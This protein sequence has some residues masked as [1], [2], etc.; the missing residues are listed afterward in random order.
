M[1]DP[2]T[3]DA[4]PDRLRLGLLGKAR[5]VTGEHAPGSP[6][7]SPAIRDLV[8]QSDLVVVDVTTP[9]REIFVEWGWGIGAK[10]QVLLGVY[11]SG[12]RE[13]HPAWVQERQ[14]R[15]FGSKSEFDEFLGQVLRILDSFPD[16]VSSWVDDPCNEPLDYKPAPQNVVLLGGLEQW[17]ALRARVAETAKENKFSLEVLDVQTRQNE[18][19]ILFDTIRAARKAATLVLTFDGSDCDLLACV[20]GGVFSM[21]DAY[22]IGSRKHQRK[23]VLLKRDGAPLPGLLATKPGVCTLSHIGESVDFLRSHFQQ[24]NGSLSSAHSATKRHKAGR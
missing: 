23:L 12:D 19:G 7:W 21:N 5:V 13:A 17:D 15:A 24:V 6:Q 18:A 2:D 8:K 20:A 3:G 11:R 22:R 4:L 14:L 1:T 9:R 10:K 16:R